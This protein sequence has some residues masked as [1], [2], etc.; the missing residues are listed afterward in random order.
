MK[1]LPLFTVA[2]AACLVSA[3]SRA[4]HEA[5]T[6]KAEFE[7]AR[8]LLLTGDFAAASQALARLVPM[9]P[10]PT[11]EKLASELLGLATTWEKGGYVLRHTSDLLARSPMQDKRTIDELA[12]LYGNAVLFGA[13][14][15]LMLDAHS[16]SS[17]AAGN[18]LPVIGMAGAAAGLV[19]G[20]DH[21]AT[22]RYGVPQSITSGMYLGFEEAMVWTLWKQA[23]TN[24]YDEWSTA[25]VATLMWS[26]AAAGALA[27]GIIGNA[28]GTTPGR[29]SFLHSAGLW[30]AAIAG[31]LAAAI[32]GDNNKADDYGL[33]SAAIALN[34]GVVA[35]GLWAS[36]ANPS[37]ARVRF[38]DLGGFSG[39]LLFGG[40]YFS[41][42]D[43]HTGM[44]GEMAALGLGMAA[45]VGLGMFWT[46]NMEPDEPRRGRESVLSSLRPSVAPAPNGS[47]ML[48]GVSGAI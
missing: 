46:R 26:G 29:A 15:G 4:A 44:A 31:T 48:V 18:I 45:G 12:V 28:Y 30:S 39:A 43:R 1:K 21:F 40:L 14:T 23:S 22:L 33:L 24:Y 6:W 10:D 35:G 3:T 2:L 42:R 41:V 13:G 11:S 7:R 19:A 32:N 8:S 5:P 37:I 27:G 38:I 20:L 25:T 17:S 9:A 16:K 34:A 47:G 36:S